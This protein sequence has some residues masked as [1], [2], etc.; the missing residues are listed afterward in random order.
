LGPFAKEDLVTS[1][2]RF[3]FATA[4]G[5]SHTRCG[6]TSTSTFLE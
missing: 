2:L 6:P 1:L 4:A 3:P 5:I